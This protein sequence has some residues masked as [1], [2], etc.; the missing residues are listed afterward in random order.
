MKIDNSPGELELFDYEYEDEDE[1]DGL[2]SES[3][4]YPI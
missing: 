3:T 1:Y 4:S 2:Y